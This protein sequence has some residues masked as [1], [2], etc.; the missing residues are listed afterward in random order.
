MVGIYPGLRS[1]DTQGLYVFRLNDKAIR[2]RLMNDAEP[3]RWSRDGRWLAVQSRREGACMVRARGGQYKCW[4]RFEALAP[5]PTGDLL[6]LA[7]PVG[8]SADKAR[9]DLYLGRR[10]GV[11]PERPK[12]LTGGVGAAAIWATPQQ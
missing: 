3:R 10:D 9:F 1:Q 8:E 4:R 5:S 11:K 12:R 7:K 2:R 6:L